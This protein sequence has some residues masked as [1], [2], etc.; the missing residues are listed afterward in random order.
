MLETIREKLLEIEEKEN[1]KIL[2][3]VESGSR[4]TGLESHDSDYDVRFVYTRKTEDYL[5]LEPARDVIEWQCDGTLDIV[6][7]DVRKALQ[8]GYR[9]NPTLLEWISSSVVYAEREEWR[10]VAE[11]IKEFF[12]VRHTAL[13]YLSMAKRN[14]A[15][16]VKLDTVKYK[17]YFYMLRPLLAVEW[18]I[19]KKEIPP[20]EL[21]ALL[22]ILQDC[23]VKKEVD[24]LIDAKRSGSKKIEGAPIAVLNEY[25]ENK[26]AELS[27]AVS[28]LPEEA[29]RD[30][31]LLDAAFLA[32]LNKR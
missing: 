29:R 20:I 17:E 11:V 4:A 23:N 28:A 9:S 8:L 31:K 24:A 30:M 16:L 26:I 7:W 3:C 5:R 25:I 14:Y 19:S 27:E 12:S 2:Y 21:E 13:Y 10:S 15:T 32:L 22:G 6:G 18:V 1:V